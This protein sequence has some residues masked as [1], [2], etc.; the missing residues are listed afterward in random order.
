MSLTALLSLYIVLMRGAGLGA[1][2]MQLDSISHIAQNS[3]LAEFHG[4]LHDRYDLF[5]VDTSYGG[6]GGGNE[7]FGQHL[8]GDMEKTRVR[9]TALPSAG[10]RN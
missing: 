1:A 4:E 3:A 5:M 7:V 9:Q 6:P 10:H 2:R 8:G